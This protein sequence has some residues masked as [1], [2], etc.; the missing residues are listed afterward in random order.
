MSGKKKLNKSTK[1]DV[2]KMLEKT[3]KVI[4]ELGEFKADILEYIN[5]ITL[6]TCHICLKLSQALNRDLKQE[7]REN[8]YF[9][10]FLYYQYCNNKFGKNWKFNLDIGTAES[11]DDVKYLI[12]DFEKEFAYLIFDC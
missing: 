11:K 3:E 8:T 9:S 5:D 7:E 2:L 4:K 6:N 10:I 12:I 1:N